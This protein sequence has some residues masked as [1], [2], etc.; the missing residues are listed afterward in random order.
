MQMKWEREIQSVLKESIT[1]NS[2]YYN[3]SE[4]NPIAFYDT[5]H[6]IIK[7][8]PLSYDKFNGLISVFKIQ[9]RKDLNNAL[10][11]FLAS[12]K[13]PAKP[14]ETPAVPKVKKPKKKIERGDDLEFYKSVIEYMESIKDFLP[15]VTLKSYNIGKSLYK[16]QNYKSGYLGNVVKNLLIAERK[17][18]Q[19]S[20]D[21][22]YAFYG[23]PRKDEDKHIEKLNS[24]ILGQIKILQENLRLGMG[25]LYIAYKIGRIPQ[26]MTWLVDVFGE[27]LGLYLWHWKQHKRKSKNMPD[28]K[29]SYGIFLKYIKG[30]TSKELGFT[31]NTYRQLRY[32]IIPQG[33]IWLLYMIHSCL[34]GPIEREIEKVKRIKEIIQGA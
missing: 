27:T 23:I 17:K 2:F 29:K 33:I 22:I 4:K 21:Y 32:E 19:L 3:Q 10:D 5:I 6:G 9:A 26:A 18:E 30:S 16:T 28:F 1:K 8:I 13:T 11:T 25:G 34:Y 15:L 24:F 20:C 14:E 31:G 7:G 12:L